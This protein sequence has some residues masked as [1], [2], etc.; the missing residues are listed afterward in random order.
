MESDIW[1]LEILEPAKTGFNRNTIYIAIPKITAPIVLKSKWIVEALFAVLLV[2]MLANT[3]VIQV[4]MFWPRVIKITEFQLKVIDIA[5]VCNIPSEAEE[6]WTIAVTKAPTNI[7]RNGLFP[8]FANASTKTG[9]FWYGL[10]APDITLSP[11][12]K[13]PNPIIISPI[14]RLFLFLPKTIW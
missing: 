13:R 11:I 10:I 14:F 2:P 6:L 12:N 4:P 8:S 5:K 9:E 7:P 3:A 1:V